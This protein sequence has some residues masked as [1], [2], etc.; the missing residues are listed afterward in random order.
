MSDYF[1]LISVSV[2]WSLLSSTVFM[3]DCSTFSFKLILLGEGVNK[4]N[5]QFVLFME[6]FVITINHISPGKI[7]RSA[8]T[9][10]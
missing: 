10:A 3:T 1:S 8:W 4:E 2:D 5:P 6:H 7:Y 9:P